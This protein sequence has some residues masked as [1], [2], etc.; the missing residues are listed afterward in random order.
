MKSSSHVQVGTERWSLR[1]K[2][3]KD[4]REKKSEE[5][6]VSSERST[7]RERDACHSGRK[8]RKK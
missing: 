3:S 6:S 8:G 4:D 2:K 1:C 7:E 5:L